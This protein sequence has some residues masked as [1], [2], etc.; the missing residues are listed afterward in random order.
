M[1]WARKKTLL[2]LPLSLN[3]S[4]RR[5]MGAVVVASSDRGRHALSISASSCSPST[6]SAPTHTLPRALTLLAYGGEGIYYFVKQFVWLAKAE[7][8]PAHLLPRLQRL[9]AWVELVGYVGSIAIKLEE[10]AKIESS[11]K[12]RLAEDCDKESETVKTMQGKLGGGKKKKNGGGW[13]IR[14]RSR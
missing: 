7:L 1:A 3:F 4:T 9:S 10:V 8:L 13:G 6:R 2:P 11:I 14:G 12:K 5:R